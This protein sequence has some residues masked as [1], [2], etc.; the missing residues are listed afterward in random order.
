MPSYRIE[1]KLGGVVAGIDEAGRGPLA[2]PVVAAAVIIDIDALPRRLAR[3]IDDSKAL[4]PEEREAIS[5]ALPPYARIGVAAA[6]VSEIERFNILR[7]T[8]MAMGRALARLGV[9]PDWALVDGDRVPPLPCRCHTVIGGDAQS[10][11][12]AAASIMAKVT[13][14][15]AMKALAR[16]YPGFGWQTNV[17][18]STA[19]HIEGLSRH[20]V[21]CHHRRTFAPVLNILSPSIPGLL[22]L[23][24]TL[25]PQD[26]LD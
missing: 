14:D 17:G 25:T 5:I 12:I 9:T 11:S 10:L 15:R 2:G 21:T 13:R 3:R 19:E 24:K 23:D 6:S 1:R 8:F 20:G 18:Y 4:E 22:D 16:R 26:Y 7:A